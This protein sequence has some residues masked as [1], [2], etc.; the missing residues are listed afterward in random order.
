MIGQTKPFKVYWLG[1]FPTCLYCNYHQPHYRWLNAWCNL[2]CRLCLSPIP[3]GV[4]GVKSSWQ[5]R[6]WI[7]NATIYDLMEKWFS[8][9]GIIPRRASRN[10]IHRGFLYMNNLFDCHF[11]TW[12][13]HLK[14]G[15]GLAAAVTRIIKLWIASGLI[16]FSIWIFVLRHYTGLKLKCCWIVQS[17]VALMLSLHKIFRTWN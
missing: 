12:P 10:H 9:M 3:F 8:A 16:V 1:L 13:E 17:L 2:D 7:K 5:F 11:T 4:D 15:S 6:L 14:W